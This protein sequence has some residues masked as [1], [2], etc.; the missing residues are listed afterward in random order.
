MQKI[1]NFIMSKKFIPILISLTAI[2]LLFTFN[3]IGSS[4]KKDDPKTRHAKILKKV[5][6]LIEEAHFSPKKIDDKFSEELLKSFVQELDDEKTIFL[7]PDIE[8]FKKFQYKMDNEIQG[9]ALE[10]FYEI[11][12]VYLKRMLNLSDMTSSI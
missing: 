12:N 3:S 5:G 11:S 10:S 4:D 1:A 7:K 2:S 6:L 8:S 9:E